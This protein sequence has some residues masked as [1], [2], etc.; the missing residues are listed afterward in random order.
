MIFLFTSIEQEEKMNFKQ[1]LKVSKTKKTLKT[2]TKNDPIYAQLFLEIRLSSESRE[3]FSEV[4]SQLE[5]MGFTKNI[6]GNQLTNF[7][8]CSLNMARFQRIFLHL[9]FESYVDGDIT[10]GHF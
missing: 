2:I 6:M 8:C 3:K 10:G 9:T 5:N 4:S 1:Q 7:K